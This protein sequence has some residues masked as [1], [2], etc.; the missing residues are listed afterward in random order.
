MPD[1]TTVRGLRVE[2]FDRGE[3]RTVLF[4]NAGCEADPEGAQALDL[5]SKRARV[6]APSHPGFGGSERPKSLS[7]VDDLAYFYLDFLDEHDLRDVAL[8]GVSFGGWIAAEIAVKS[9]ARLSHVVLADA[10]G[11]K[12]GDR[13]S[14]DIAD[15]FAMTEPEFLAA[16]YADASA[17]A[18]D[19]KAMPDTATLT[20]ARNRET[21]ARYAW[22]P[23]MHDP[24]LK[25]R[26]HRIKVPTLCLWGARDRIVTPDYGR[27]YCAAIPGATF[28]TIASA[29]HLP[30]VE[31]PKAFAD[32]VLR[33][34]G[35]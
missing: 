21:L 24:K 22:S 31:Q 18:R 26:L 28:E 10:V 11:I 9:T 23:Y 13:E 27:A 4:L 15:I 17:G 35:A 7:T 5:M 34:I 3:G 2:T 30:H 32:S 33:F 6:I 12:T 1:E 8:V 16:A 25:S 29:G 19:Y 20:I 14:R